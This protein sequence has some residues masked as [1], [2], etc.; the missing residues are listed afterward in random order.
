MTPSPYVPVPLGVDQL[1]SSQARI[2][3]EALKL[4]LAVI[5][6]DHLFPGG[7]PRVEA[8]TNGLPVVGLGALSSDAAS[9]FAALLRGLGPSPPDRRSH[10]A[11][12]TR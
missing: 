11:A 6:A 4:A 12:E 1:P 10:G 2:A 3:A 9:Q 7:W 5:C 8:D